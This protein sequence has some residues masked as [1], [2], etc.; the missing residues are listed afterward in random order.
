[1]VLFFFSL[2]ILLFFLQ[3]RMAV[4]AS[5]VQKRKGG[6]RRGQCSKRSVTEAKA[7]EP[8]PEDD[9][10]RTNSSACPIAT[11]KGGFLGLLLVSRKR[12]H[13]QLTAAEK[14]KT[15]KKT[16]HNFS[17]IKWNYNVFAAK[18]NGHV[19]KTNLNKLF[20]ET[21]SMTGYK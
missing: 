17:L 9:I 6:N 2:V 7:H 3:W 1:M 18:Q 11:S 13:F 14:L 21:S 5:R 10:R 19:K 15:K 16:K 4:S 20:Q 12:K 8:S